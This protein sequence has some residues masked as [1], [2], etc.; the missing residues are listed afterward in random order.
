MKKLRVVIDTNIIL[1]SLSRTSPNNWLFQ[2]LI[3][4]DFEICVT[5]EILLE[6][7][8]II[9]QKMTVRAAEG[10]MRLFDALDNVVYINTYF[11]FRLLKDPDDNK[12][13]DCAIAA[14]AN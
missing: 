10:M 4:E 13:V 2:K 7:Y 6:Y 11:E 3:D 1:V 12:F 8:E 5:T 9:S 14:D